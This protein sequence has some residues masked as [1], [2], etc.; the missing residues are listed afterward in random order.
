MLT[1]SRIAQHQLSLTGE[2]L[3]YPA[4]VGWLIL[5][6]NKEADKSIARSD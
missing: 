6:D 3:K 5:F 2:T 4:T 1:K